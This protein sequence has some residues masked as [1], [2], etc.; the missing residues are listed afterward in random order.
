M[1]RTRARQMDAEPRGRAADR[2]FVNALARGLDVLRAF[3][4]GD[5]H[6]GNGEIAE[7]TGLPKPTV[8][9]LT[10]TLMKLGYLTHLERLSRYQLAPGALSLG[11]A[12]L[13]NF[14][15]R[16]LARPYMQRLADHAGGSVALGSRDR[17]AMIYIGLCRASTA[18]TVRLELGSRI[19]IATTAMGRAYLAALVERE[20]APVLASLR[21]RAGGEWARQEAGILEG[22]AQMREQGFTTSVGAWKEDVNAV[23]IAFRAADGSGVY[24]FN[25]GAPAF[26]F[27]RENLERDLGPRLIA[28]ARDVEGALRGESEGRPLATGAEDPAP[29]ADRAA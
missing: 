4:P 21:Q 1:S 17:L 10:Y 9:R 12:A 22:I 13:A 26:R 19:P 5:G 3:R 7:R 11:Y 16:D 25:C 24:A 29:R 8:S 28:L 23:G 2:Q 6:L 20:R 18:L 14:G 27:S 15:I